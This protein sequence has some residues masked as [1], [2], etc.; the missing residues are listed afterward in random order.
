MKQMFLML[1]LA[2]TLAAQ[3]VN[4]V[5][6]EKVNSEKPFYFP[7]FSPDGKS[8]LVTTESYKGLYLLN[9]RN[10]TVREITDEFGAGYKARFDVSG[11]KI[12]YRSF[13]FREGK[14]YSSEILFDLVNG[15]RNVLESNER[16]LTPPIKY[17]NGEVFYLKE[18]KRQVPE[19]MEKSSVEKKRAA[20]VRDRQIVFLDGES[21]KTLEPLGKGIYVWAS[22]SPDGQ[23]IAFTFGANG[24]FVCDMEGNVLKTLGDL[25]YP[26][27]SPDGKWIAGMNDKDDGYVYTSSDVVVV[28]YGNLK[29]FNI[30]QSGD[31]IEMYPEWSPDGKKLA[32]HDLKGNVYVAKLILTEE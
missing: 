16:N 20:F 18:G 2:G 14:K 19:A 12:F 9:L 32:F 31:K 24:S 23:K 1:L 29:R 3:S 15:F 5:S 28:Y 30:T 7:K 13:K 4:V 26:R 6:I 8:L 21:E 25:H 22:L 17:L 27:W 11:K 10:A